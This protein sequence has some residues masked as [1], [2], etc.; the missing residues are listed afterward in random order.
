MLN[1]KA[2]VIKCQ[3]G[4]KN[5][6]ASRVAD[7]LSSAPCSVRLWAQMWSDVSLMAHT[8]FEKPYP[9]LLKQEGGASFRNS[10]R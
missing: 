4:W 2:P 3:L 9:L 5:N 8:S 7:C 6:F 10:H 1:D